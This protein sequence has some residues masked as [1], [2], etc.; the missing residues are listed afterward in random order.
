MFIDSTA[1]FSNTKL[2]KKNKKKDRNSVI[3]RQSSISD[4]N[5]ALEIGTVPGVSNI[6]C[7]VS[8]V[9][10]ENDVFMVSFDQSNTNNANND[11][12]DNSDNHN[13]KTIINDNDNDRYK[14]IMFE[15]SV[16]RQ[17]NSQS[18]NKNKK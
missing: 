13:N 7:C 18:K 6:D 15:H 3:S 1:I 17:N 10:D 14:G 5:C 12:S 2:K 4:I 16:K 8:P 9:I 11:K